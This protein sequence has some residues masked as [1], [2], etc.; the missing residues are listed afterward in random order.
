MVD[1]IISSPSLVTAL[2]GRLG[3]PEENRVPLIGEII[4]ASKDTARRRLLNQGDFSLDEL[5]RIARYFSTTISMMLRETSLHENI[6]PAAE[7]AHVTID[8]I[9]LPCRV[10]AR[11]VHHLATTGLFAYADAAGGRMVGTAAAAPLGV[12]LRPVVELQISEQNFPRVRVAVVDDEAPTTLVRYLNDAGFDAAHYC[13][14]EPVIALLGSQR[15]PDAYILDW[16]LAKGRNSRQLIE[17]IRSIDATVPIL[18]LTGTI[19]SN[20]NNETDIGQMMAK[21]GVEV[22]LKPARLV[23]IANKLRI[24]LNLEEVARR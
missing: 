7:E 21:H 11:S 20:P 13:E 17:A 14:A 23:L 8:G 5:T 19:E 1:T 18:L 12:E 4:G 9:K 22:F 6:D 3:I 2:L 15:R 16:T 24:M 10:V